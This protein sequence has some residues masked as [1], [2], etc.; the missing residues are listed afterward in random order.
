M[1]M[2]ILGRKLGMTQI[3]DENGKSIPVTVVEAGPCSVVAVRTMAT[4]GYSS[5]SL[6]FGDIKPAKLNKPFRGVFEKKNLEPKRWIREFR[7]DDTDGFEVGGVVSVAL[8]EAGESVDVVGKSKGKG[9]AGV[10][11]RHHFHGGPASHGASKFHR[12]PGSGGASSYPGHIF[13]G[14]PMPGRMGN[15]RVTVKNLSIAG[16]DLENNLL[17]IKGAVPGP[18]NGLVMVRKQAGA[19]K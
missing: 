14:K 16:I 4:N 15:V 9:F 1:G 12:E 5:V 3:F 6:G 8:F 2:G 17:L 19:P 10:I 18:R 7:L 13:K 11:K